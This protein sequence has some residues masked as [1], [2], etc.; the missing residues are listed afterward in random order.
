MISFLILSLIVLIVTSLIIIINS[1]KG[2]FFDSQYVDDWIAVIW[3]TSGYIVLSYLVM[4]IFLF[5]P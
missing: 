3:A 1:P 5:L 2:V 4:A